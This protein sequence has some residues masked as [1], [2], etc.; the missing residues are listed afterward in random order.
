MTRNSILD[1]DTPRK[2]AQKEMKEV[3]LELM[4]RQNYIC[5][6]CK[7]K[8]LAKEISKVALDHCHD[9][10]YIRGVLHMRCNRA[11]GAVKTALRTW[12]GAPDTPKGTLKTIDSL[13][14]YLNASI[15]NPILLIYPKHKT[16]QELAIAAA[17]K[18]L[19]QRQGL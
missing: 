13:R 15:E 18:A 8:L 3:K 11:E 14:D 2:L 5:P 16:K 7:R 1:V 19:K 17:K 10:G 12:C 6:L 4:K 9:T